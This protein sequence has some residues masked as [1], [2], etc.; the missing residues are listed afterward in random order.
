M[1]SDTPTTECNAN[2]RDKI[3][4]L[5]YKGLQQLPTVLTETEDFKHITNLYL[6][7]NCLTTLPERI[8]MLQNLVVLYLH[9]NKLTALPNTI[10][11]LSNLECLD[12]GSNCLTFLPE[13]IGRLAKL[14]S[15]KLAYNMVTHMPKSVGNLH[16]LV[17]LEA[18]NNR[19]RSLPLELFDCRNLEVLSVDSN[20]LHSIPR[21]IC[22]LTRLKEMSA[23]G[24]N[25]IMLPQD[26]GTSENL[27]SIFVDCN[28]YLTVLP[29]DLLKRQVG[30]Y[31]CGSLPL[32]KLSDAILSNI[33][34][35]TV[36]HTETCSKA[37]P[38]PWEIRKVG[39][40]TDACVPTLLELALRCTHSILVH[41]TDVR[42]L[43]E[44]PRCSCRCCQCR[45]PSV[46]SVSAQCSLWLSPWCFS[47]S[48]R[49][50]V[51]TFLLC[52]VLFCVFASVCS[53]SISLLCTLHW[54]VW[55][56]LLPL[57]DYHPR[58]YSIKCLQSVTL[59]LQLLQVN[60]PGVLTHQEHVS[61]FV[62]NPLGGLA[63]WL[64][65]LLITL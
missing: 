65:H 14:T 16:H 17:S 51:F 63:W 54:R 52:V 15:L 64:K 44:V 49:E 34:C 8:D 38:L 36:K 10:G 7:R 2:K 9:S 1:T 3:L 20:Q 24:N 21:Q 37:L 43:E 58:K 13:S 29:I 50:P 12:V 39:N 56:S 30:F 26:M 40:L 27:K 60:I 31:R 48:F 45:L 42:Y 33:C 18:M 25:I 46:T 22:K 61:Y 41:T 5:N 19:L 47:P 11:D 6:K 57:S 28:C 59:R 53:W 4:Q 23:T 32:S 55:V 35:V 62:L